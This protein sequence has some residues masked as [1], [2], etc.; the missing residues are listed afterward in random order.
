M[1]TLKIEHSH[2]GI[3]KTTSDQF[4]TAYFETVKDAKDFISTITK[5]ADF[6]GYTWEIGSW[7]QIISQDEN[8]N[9]TKIGKRI[10]VK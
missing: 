6:Y 1:K 7:F 4:K 9:I 10:V 5:G 2:N 8:E 3:I